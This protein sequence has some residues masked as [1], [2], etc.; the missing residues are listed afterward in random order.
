[1]EYSA[2][3]TKESWSEKEM[4]ITL[5]L[6]LK[7]YERKEVLDKILNENLYQLRSPSSIQN[8]FQMVYRR[9]KLL[10]DTLKEH[11]L[12]ANAH[13]RK[14]LILLSFNLAYRFPKEFFFE[15]LVIKYLQNEKLLKS[16]IGYYFEK[17]ALESEK[18]KQWRPETIKRLISTLIL[19]FRQSG[20][21]EATSQ[22]EYKIYPLYISK[23]LKDYAEKNN[24]LLNHFSELSR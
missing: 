5:N 14:A 24:S 10:D 8:R 11:F 21:I 20:I 23:T 1:M 7:G 17:K 4:E 19:F 16:D 15:V 18:V 3:F 12:K 9:S 6:I 2:G 13:D 22:Q